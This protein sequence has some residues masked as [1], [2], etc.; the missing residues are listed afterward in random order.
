VA[1][2]KDIKDAECGVVPEK[3]MTVAQKVKKGN[4]LDLKIMTSAAL[5]ICIVAGLL[6]I[7]VLVAHCGK[8]LSLSLSLK[9]QYI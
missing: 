4:P 7:T 5:F 1:N 6:A 3:K 2:I 9:S 8:S